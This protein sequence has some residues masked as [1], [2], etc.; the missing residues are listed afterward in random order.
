MLGQGV[1]LVC[2]ATF[3]DVQGEFG[4]C[5]RC[6]LK[7]DLHGPSQPGSQDSAAPEEH[8]LC[9]GSDDGLQS[10]ELDQGSQLQL[11]I[12]NGGL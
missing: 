3:A 6:G 1:R 11:S 4:E 12:V 5:S 9:P 2:G 10:A 8:L 7:S